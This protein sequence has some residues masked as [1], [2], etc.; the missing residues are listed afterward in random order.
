MVS[1]FGTIQSLE[2]FFLQVDA[3]D[4]NEAEC[5]CS[6][7]CTNFFQWKSGSLRYNEIKIM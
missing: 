2:L 4:W 5:L 1:N 3:L 6:A 7:D